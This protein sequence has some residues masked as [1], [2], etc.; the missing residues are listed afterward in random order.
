M[1]QSP[2][3]AFGDGLDGFLCFAVYSANLAFNRVYKPMLDALGLTYPQYLALVALWTR[4]D[5]TVGG[6]GE[7]LFLESN[8]LTPLLKR[9]EAEGLVTRRRD[10]KDERQVRVSL[11]A[12]GKALGERARCVPD[13]ILQATGLSEA[14]LL[15]LT[16]ELAALRQHLLAP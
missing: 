16:R 2:P 4:D 5:Q 15:R 1:T 6:L 8:T 10:P 3:A 7:Q 9:L 13:Q 11:T 12:A 14:D